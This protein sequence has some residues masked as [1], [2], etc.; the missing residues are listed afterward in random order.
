MRLQRSKW[1]NGRRCCEVR[2]HGGE[3]KSP[4]WDDGEDRSRCRDVEVETTVAAECAEQR[5][6]GGWGGPEES[7]HFWWTLLG[8]TFTALFWK[9]ILHFLKRELF[10]NFCWLNSSLYGPHHWICH[11]FTGFSCSRCR[12][13]ISG[14][15]PLPVWGCFSFSG[16]M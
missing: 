12:W 5:P 6:D 4:F 15:Q 16:K 11:F 3:T 2:E 1:R 8:F 7:P 10:M 14:F 13:F 9:Q